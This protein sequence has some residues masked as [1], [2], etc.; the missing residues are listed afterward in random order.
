MSTV[1]KAIIIGFLGADPELR[2]TQ[3]GKAVAELRLATNEKFGDIES[4]EWHRVILWEKTAEVAAKYL[5]KGSQVY[6]EGRIQTRNYEDSD[7]V[8]RYITEIVASRMQMLGAKPG[9]DEEE[10]GQAAQ[11]EA[12]KPA[13]KRRG[14]PKKVEAQFDADGEIP[15]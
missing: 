10:E 5:N 6:I 12:P 11:A 2:H 14:R 15:F 7:G 9:S 8:K 4:T 1:N 13:G 3:S